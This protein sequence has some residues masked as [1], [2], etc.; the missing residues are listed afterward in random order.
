MKMDS[1]NGI[2][3]CSLFGFG[4]SGGGIVGGKIRILNCGTSKV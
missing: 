3:S 2:F 1:S 4:D